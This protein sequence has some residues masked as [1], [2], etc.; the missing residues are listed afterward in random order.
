[1][2][3]ATASPARQDPPGVAVAN[4]PGF[5]IPANLVELRG[6][7]VTLQVERVYELPYPLPDTATVAPLRGR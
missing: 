2:N 4:L 3:P 6:H 7:Q 5:D 1:M